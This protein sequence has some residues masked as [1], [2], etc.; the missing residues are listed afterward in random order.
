FSRVLFR[1]RNVTVRRG[2]SE[3]GVTTIELTVRVHVR[4]LLLKQVRVSTAHTVRGKANGRLTAVNLHLVRGLVKQTLRDST[5][6]A[7]VV[8]NDSLPHGLNRGVDVVESAA[9][10]NDSA[11]A[12]PLTTVVARDNENL[13]RRRSLRRTVKGNGVTRD[14][15]NLATRNDRSTVRLQ[16]IDVV[17]QVK[18][19]RVRNRQRVTRTVSGNGSERT[20]T[21]AVNLAVQVNT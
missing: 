1:S 5:R 7:A 2:I 9:V 3:S 4:T 15:G 13:A 11:K 18:E 21:V 12:R 6:S 8:V 19:R 10:L 14:T 20:R 16:D 17:A